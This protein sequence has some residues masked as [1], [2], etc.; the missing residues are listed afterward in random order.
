MHG[1]MVLYSN[2]DSAL[3]FVKK[4]DYRSDL[5]LSK[6][7]TPVA[8]V[9]VPASHTSD[10]TARCI[11]INS[12]HCSTP[13]KG[14]STWQHMMLAP[15]GNTS[16]TNYNTYPIGS[17]PWSTSTP[18]TSTVSGS[19]GGNIYPSFTKY[20]R[21]TIS[22]TNSSNPTL[23]YNSSSSSSERP[24]IP[25]KSDGKTK[26]SAYNT[27]CMKDMDGKANCKVYLTA[28]GT[29][30]YST[31]K[32]SSG[33]AS[34]YPAISCAD[35]YYTSGTSQGDWY[36]PAIGELCYIPPYVEKIDT[37]IR[38][39][40]GKGF[41]NDPYF[42]GDGDLFLWS[43]TESSNGYTWRLNVWDCGFYSVTKTNTI[44]GAYA[45]IKL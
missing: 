43:S 23:Y 2:L 3:H 5:F 8:V 41:Q 11:S 16:L 28:R 20:M 45:F 14:S 27:G 9:V 10:G 34:N 42:T 40:G 39:L 1:D 30:D 15:S 7:F 19:G 25:Y 33:T 12:M 35:M 29:K 18:S 13:T 31:W 17:N 32:P 6:W 36:I 38:T 37:S 44:F 24:P 21:Y 22:Y 26:N 4:D